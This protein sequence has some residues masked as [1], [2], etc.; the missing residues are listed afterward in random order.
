M[1]LVAL[2]CP[3]CGGNVDMY[4]DR[5]FGQCQHCGQNIVIDAGMAKT[6]NIK[7]ID[8]YS[9][10]FE[11]AKYAI[12]TEDLKRVKS[13]GK[14]L[15]T[16]PQDPH[17]WLLRGCVALTGGDITS[18]IPE[19]ITETKEPI[20]S[21]DK[22]ITG[23]KDE[24][25]EEEV[26]HDDLKNWNRAASCWKRAAQYLDS[27]YYLKEYAEIIGMSLAP[28]INAALCKYRKCDYHE[29][30]GPFV[31]AVRKRF[32][33]D[34]ASE[35]YYR[36]YTGYKRY[37]LSVGEDSDNV[38][39]DPLEEMMLNSIAYDPDYKSLIRK[40]KDILDYFDY[41]DEWY[42]D[43]RH[44]FEQ[45]VETFTEKTKKLSPRERERIASAWTEMRMEEELGGA[46]SDL[47]RS[48]KYV[49]KKVYIRDKMA[50]YA[51]LYL[52]P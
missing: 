22:G 8:Q 7:M 9:L 12:E 41:S 42:M 37:V 35:M 33:I 6:V 1:R 44:I 26:C 43:D 27:Q 20:L 45:F 32:N 31:E 15:F 38:D 51:D 14:K 2:S 30:I 10:L 29:I 17:A 47:M 3:K 11:E 48:G 5:V 24:N 36:L 16:D 50:I 52:N 4:E 28:V 34:F 25:D 21:K 19:E 18:S 13:I 40:C 39:L 46:W 23:S 49:D